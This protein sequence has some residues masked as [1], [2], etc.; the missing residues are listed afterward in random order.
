MRNTSK[1]QHKLI[2]LISTICYV[3]NRFKKYTQND[4]LYYF[5]GNIKRN[6]QKEVKLKTLQSYLYKLKKELKVTDNHHKHL[7]INMGTEIYYKLKYSK[8]ECYRQINKYFKNKKEDK[9]Q[10]RITKN[11][12]KIYN[13]N[14]SVEKW[15][16]INNIYNNKREYKDKKLKEESQVKKYAK[17]C[18]FKSKEFLSILNLDINKDDKIRILKAIKRAENYIMN[19][20]SEKINDFIINRNKLKSKQEKL[21]EVLNEIKTQLES[22]KYDSKQVEMQIQ[23]AYERYK[24]KPHFIIEDDK[25]DDCKKMINKIKNSIKNFNKNVE[26]NE[27]TVR[28]NI[29]SILFE[30]LK[31]KFETNIF[32]PVL[33]DYLDRQGKLDYNKAFNNQYYY[34]LLKLIKNKENYSE[35]QGFKEIVN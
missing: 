7:G 21:K 35:L 27:Q 28:V 19:N 13:K 5:N 31:S 25:Y 29:F 23:E 10:K 34:E 12:K 6:G 17:K 24:N 33:K 22:E 2:V 15:E 26:K 20:F 1:H 8:K 18:H 30:Q 11:E 9:F 3:N 32:I 4:I 14:G 16:C